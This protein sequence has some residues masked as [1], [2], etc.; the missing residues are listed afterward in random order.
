MLSQEV[1]TF[2]RRILERC[3]DK[4]NMETGVISKIENG[5][6]EIVAVLSHTQVF[7]EG[8][9]YNYHST[10]CEEL[11]AN[12]QTIAVD[13]CFTLPERVPHPLYL[14]QTMKSYIGT[15]INIYGTIWGALDFTSFTTRQQP[16][17]EEEIRFIE[18]CA[19]EIANILQRKAARTG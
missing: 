17:S 3:K 4:L 8:E 14:P 12:N 16:F 6:Y 2:C 15:P 11:I 19:V 9:S 7:V 18:S 10:I 5:R 13:D 1:R